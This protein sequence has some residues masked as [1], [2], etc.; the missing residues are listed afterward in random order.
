MAKTR[1]RKQKTIDPTP[2][3][4]VGDTIK[5]P[6]YGV[7]V[8]KKIDTGMFPDYDFFYDADFTGKGGDGTKVWLPKVKT[9]RDCE[10][11]A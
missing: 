7:G 1:K 2:V 3:F 8:I 6:K 5:H 10:K 4:A 11:V 9:E